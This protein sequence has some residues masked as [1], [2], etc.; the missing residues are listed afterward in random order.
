MRIQ[1]PLHGLARTLPL[2]Y[3]N[4]LDA[5]VYHEVPLHPLKRLFRRTVWRLI[6]VLSE[7]MNMA[8]KVM[9]VVRPSNG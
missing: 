4:E 8:D 1:H 2:P 7:A 9:I 6:E 3:A 5:E